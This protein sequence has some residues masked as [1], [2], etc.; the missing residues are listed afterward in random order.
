M[1]NLNVKLPGIPLEWLYES[2]E[3]YDDDNDNDWSR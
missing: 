2:Q 3:D 1:W